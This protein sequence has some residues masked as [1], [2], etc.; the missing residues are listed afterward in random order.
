M[1]ESHGLTNFIYGSLGLTKPR[2]CKHTVH[3]IYRRVYRHLSPSGLH[4]RI[5][6]SLCKK[7]PLLLGTFTLLVP[8]SDPEIGLNVLKIVCEQP[9]SFIGHIDFPSRRRC[10]FGRSI[11][12]AS[13]S[14]FYIL[15]SDGN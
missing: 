15:F 6:M 2:S 4:S 12:K 8:Q 1:R 5:D 3:A 11:A 9:R 10:I 13:W 14:H 7:F